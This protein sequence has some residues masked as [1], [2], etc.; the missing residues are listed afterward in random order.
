MNQDS[1]REKVAIVTGG[2]AG[3]G[4]SLAARLGGLGARVVLAARDEARL[5]EASQALKAAGIETLG[6]PTDVTKDED[7]QRLIAQTLQQ[8]GRI[9]ALFNNAGRSMRSRVMDTPVAEFQEL[10]DVN[11][12]STVRCTGAAMPALLESRGHVVNVGSLACKAAAR[13]LGAYPASKAP[14]VTYS[15]QL[16]LELEPEGVHVLLV[17]PGPIARQDTGARYDDQAQDLP[18]EARKAGGGVKISGIAPETLADKILKACDQRK[19]EL[20]VPTRARF[21][22]ALSQLSPRLGDWIIGRMTS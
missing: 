15:Q 1:W 4:K 19:A 11:F 17:C 3:L 18:A 8:F 9:D 13:Y 12:L 20:V 2:S 10:W 22:F 5:E 7:V 21:L 16:R 6:V 14:L